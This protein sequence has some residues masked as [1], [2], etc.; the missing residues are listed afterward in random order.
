MSG[1]PHPFEAPDGDERPN[2]TGGG[3]NST[4]TDKLKARIA[5]LEEAL[6][7]T[8]ARKCDHSWFVESC[9][10]CQSEIKRHSK[11]MRERLT[12][13]GMNVREALDKL[14]PH[15][16]GWRVRD[17][18]RLAPKIE[19]ALRASAA[20]MAELLTRVGVEDGLVDQC[21]TAGVAAMVEEK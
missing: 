3:M 14:T 6:A 1:L 21:V 2:R 8:A 10:E 17:L 15:Y 18:N 9:G 12:G 5:E 7:A 20:E 11:R 4:E 13:G 16:D 19:R